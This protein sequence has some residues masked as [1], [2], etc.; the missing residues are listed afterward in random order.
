MPPPLESSRLTDQTHLRCM[1]PRCCRRDALRTEEPVNLLDKKRGFWAAIM[2]RY[3]AAH[4]LPAASVAIVGLLAGSPAS[5][6]G[7]GVLTGKVQDAASNKPLGDAVITLT[8]P[9]LQGEQTVVS[10]GSG[11]Y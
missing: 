8:S 10:D 6:Q 4:L 7:T 1:W 3:R 9:A 5:A 2:L 11:S